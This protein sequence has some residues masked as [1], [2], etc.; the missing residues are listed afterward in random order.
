MGRLNTFNNEKSTIERLSGYSL[1]L[2]CIAN[3]AAVYAM[4]L[5]RQFKRYNVEVRMI[6]FQAF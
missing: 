5:Y 2:L 3:Y 4:L 6:S 1:M